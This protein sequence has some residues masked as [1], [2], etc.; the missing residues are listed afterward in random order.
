LK[1]KSTSPNAI[2][3]KNQQKTSDNKEKSDVIIG[4]EKDE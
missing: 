1:H 3:V 4:L 2:Q